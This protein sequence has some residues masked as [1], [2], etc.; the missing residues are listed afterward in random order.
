MQVLHELL[1][2]DVEIGVHPLVLDV[3]AD[4][5][6]LS[7][8]EDDRV[9]EGQSEDHFLVLVRLGEVFFIVLLAQVT[10]RAEDTS[11]QTSRRFI[12]QLDSTLEDGHWEGW[13]GARSEP[14]T[15]LRVQLVS[16]GLL[17]DH[18]ELAHPRSEQ[19]TVL[20]ADPVTS[21]GALFDEFLS[22]HVLSLTQRDR[23][24]LLVHSLRDGES[25]QVCDGVSTW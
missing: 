8:F 7:A 15:V 21:T 20:E 25:S 23:A 13:C 17:L 4:G 22:D 19:V 16:I 3:P 6:V 5:T 14:K 12:G 9:E 11:L 1:L 2:R 18:F 24:Q 10:E